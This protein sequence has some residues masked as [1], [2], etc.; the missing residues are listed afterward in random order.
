M[1]THIYFRNLNIKKVKILPKDKQ[2][3]SK[4]RIYGLTY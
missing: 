2:M 4:G 1:N 3:G